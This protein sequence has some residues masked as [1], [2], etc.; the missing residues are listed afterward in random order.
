M[1]RQET[2]LTVFVASPSDVEDERNKLEEAIRNLNII[3]A[4]QLG[5][6]LD[7]VMWETHAYPGF[8]EDPQFVIN[9]QIPQDYDL[10]IGI[11]WYRFGTPTGRAGSGTVEEFQLAK[12]RHDQDP[13]SIHLMFYFKDAPA[14]VSPSRL[15]VEQIAN[16]NKFRSDLGKE[17]GLYWIFN[18]ANDFEKLVQVHLSRFI[19]AWM[20]GQIDSHKIE[21]ES[22]TVDRDPKL[23]DQ[24]LAEDEP[25]LL[26]LLEQSDSEFEAL[27]EIIERITK[28]MTDLGEKIGA[29][30]GELNILFNDEA[31][32]RKSMKRI[33]S[34]IAADMDNYVDRMDLE[35]PSLSHHL[36]KGI[37]FFAQ[38]SA[39]FV[40][41]TPNEDLHEK[42]NSNLTD[43]NS[44]GIT[45]E[46]VKDT[47]TEFR[48]IVSSLPRMATAFNRSKREMLKVLSN[49]ITTL[50]SATKVI[51]EIR[52]STENMLNKS[53]SQLEK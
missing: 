50:S 3:W 44:L 43:L 36:S 47:M 6:R 32:D 48:H 42:V 10:F 7:L 4:R 40:D 1:T 20:N 28:D 38:A 31:A 29:R 34:K 39:L 24:K 8:G 22:G 26:D 11:M 5:I 18:T 19:Q 14:P 17:G 49:L 53:S 27:G 21:E 35:L 51:D 23:E 30:T 52:I 25:G 45:I 15:D 2:I 12:S 46:S 33:Y 37:E 13:S 9:E 16:V 41:F